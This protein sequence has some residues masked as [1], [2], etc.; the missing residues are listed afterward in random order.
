MY[1]LLYNILVNC[2]GTF[3]SKNVKEYLLYCD[4]CLVEN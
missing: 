3:Y 2:S 4:V 1:I